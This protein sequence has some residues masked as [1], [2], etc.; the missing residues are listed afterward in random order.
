MMERKGTDVAKILKLQGGRPLS[1]NVRVQG[2]KNAATKMMIASLLTD[3]EVVLENCPEIEDVAITAEICAHVG[4]TV[5]RGDGRV[6]LRTPEIHGTKV[7]ELSS[8]NRISIL[9]LSPLLHRAGEAELP[10]VGGDAIGPR[11]VNFHLD[12]LR[13]MGAVI[14]ET[15]NS[16]VATAPHG[17]HG[18]V[19]TLPY[20]SVVRPRTSFWQRCE[21]RAERGSKTPR[22][23]R[24]CSTW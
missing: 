23:S 16:Y 4:A 21:P 5:Q 10:L 13:A 12:A 19:I 1:G 3:E 20:P 11:P 8:R 9:A 15:D 22:S 7:T 2:A 14:N 18:T 17:L 24:N 6:S